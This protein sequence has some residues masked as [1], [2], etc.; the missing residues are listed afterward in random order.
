MQGRFPIFI[1]LILFNF[2]CQPSVRYSR[3]ANPAMD[4]DYNRPDISARLQTF[5]REWLHTPY[6]YGG[7]GKDG[8]DCSGL[9][10]QFMKSAY[11]LMIPRQSRDQYKQG[12]KILRSHLQAGNLV[13]FASYRGYDVDHVGIYLGDGKFIHA[14][15]SEGVIIS[16]L[17]ED[18]YSARYAGACRYR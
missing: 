1:I 5:V 18:Y 16:S 2:S 13:F 3:S 11:G 8:I 9:A 17:D 12:E 6:K 15:A 4:Q 14:T 10:V 7:A